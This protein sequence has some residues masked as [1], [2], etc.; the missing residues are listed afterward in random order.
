MNPPCL[1]CTED[2]QA[3]LFS[4]G[5]AILCRHDATT[6]PPGVLLAEGA[7]QLLRVT[8]APSDL[9]VQYTLQSLMQLDAFFQVLVAHAVQ[10]TIPV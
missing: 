5:T 1:K 8:R 2:V 10:Q 9:A 6:G 7:D 4:A 3:K